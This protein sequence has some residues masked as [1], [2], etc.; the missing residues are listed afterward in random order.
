MRDGNSLPKSGRT[1]TFTIKNGLSKAFDIIEATGLCNQ[2]D[3][4]VDSRSLV[5]Y[6]RMQINRLHLQQISYA[7]FD[8]QKLQC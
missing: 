3:K 6:L 5:L 2:V 8:P 7:H 1:F 4:T